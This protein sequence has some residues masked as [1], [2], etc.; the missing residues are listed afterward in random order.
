MHWVPCSLGT[1]TATEA[2]SCPV[3][4]T[5]HSPH[6]LCCSDDRGH[7]V[8]EV[9]G[10]TQRGWVG[11]YSNQGPLYFSGLTFRQLLFPRHSS[12]PKQGQPPV[13]S[14]LA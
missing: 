12:Q 11:R 1:R 9:T 2:L 14:L 3:S 4:P 8:P 6:R 7:S 5:Y 10:N 13:P